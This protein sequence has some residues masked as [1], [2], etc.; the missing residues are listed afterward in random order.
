VHLIV[1]KKILSSVFKRLNYILFFVV[2]VSYHTVAQDYLKSGTVEEQ[3]N[4]MLDKSETYITL[5]IP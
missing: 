5:E 1:N 4:N 2:L 3:F